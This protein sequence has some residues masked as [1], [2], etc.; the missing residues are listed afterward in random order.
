M[1]TNWVTL[2]VK[3]DVH[4]FAKSTGIVIAVCLGITKGLQNIVGFYENIFDS[5]NV[6]LFMLLCVLI[7]IFFK[8]F[9][10]CNLYNNSKNNKWC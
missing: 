7:N 3:V 9:S 5:V 6:S 4:V 10:T 1:A 8:I 2:E